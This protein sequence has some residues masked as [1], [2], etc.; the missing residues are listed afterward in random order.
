LKSFGRSI[1]IWCNFLN[2]AILVF[3]AFWQMD[4]FQRRPLLYSYSGSLPPEAQP[5]DWETIC[6]A[7]PR[8][9][10]F[11]IGHFSSRIEYA[12]REWQMLAP[13]AYATQE[14][15]GAVRNREARR[16][17]FRKASA[18]GGCP[19]LVASRFWCSM[20]AEGIARAQMAL[21]ERSKRDRTNS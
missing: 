18:S 10:L 20:A 21:G 6:P 4:G 3:L 11:T 14:F 13:L 7:Q 19:Q 5:Q 8:I 15:D 9:I 12:L 17:Q 1:E 16:V 2:V